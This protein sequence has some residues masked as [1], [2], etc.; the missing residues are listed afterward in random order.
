MRRLFMTAA[1]LLLAIAGTGC[2]TRYVKQNAFPQA[3]PVTPEILEEIS[4]ELFESTETEPSS[5]E[6]LPSETVVPLPDDS[7]VYWLS[8]GKVCHTT[9]TCRYIK[10]REDI[11][12]GTLAEARNAGKGD[13]CSVCYPVN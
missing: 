6:P 4:R 2:S 12:V 11:L 10:D 13:V 7:T 5:N 8:G 1:A 9:A 3:V